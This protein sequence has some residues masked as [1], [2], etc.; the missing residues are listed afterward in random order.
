MITTCVNKFYMRTG[1]R[2]S[3][4][5]AIVS[6]E[7]TEAW[8]EA[9]DVGMTDSM[10]HR[11]QGFGIVEV[12]KAGGVRLT[13]KGRDL[14]REHAGLLLTAMPDQSVIALAVPEAKVL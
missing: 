1:L 13:A 4:F 6:L 2:L 8:Q 3:D 11:L 7:G 9:V 12:N 10:L 5:E 14:A